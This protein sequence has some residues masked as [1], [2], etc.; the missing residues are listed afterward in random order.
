M[1]YENLV[2]DFANRTRINLSI[3]KDKAEADQ[4]AYEV[5]QL[6]N[7]MLG[8]LVFPREEFFEKIPETNLKNLEKDGWPIP[9]IRGK[10]KQASNLKQLI[11]YLR[12]GIVHFNINFTETYGVIDGLIIWNKSLKGMKNWEVELKIKE[13]D[14]FTDRI[15]RLILK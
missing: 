15:T 2:K 1:I 10:Y 6:I 8:L 12:N 9:R 14:A 5:T 3:I 7:S 13:L 4:N 11:R